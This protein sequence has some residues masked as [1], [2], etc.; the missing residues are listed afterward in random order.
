MVNLND[1]LFGDVF[2]RA[3]L[4]GLRAEL[5]NGVKSGAHLPVGRQEDELDLLGSAVVAQVVAVVA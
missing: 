5:V 2:R 4:T 3:V 1:H